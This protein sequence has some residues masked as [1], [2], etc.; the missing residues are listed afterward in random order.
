MN[1]EENMRHSKLVGIGAVAMMRDS[2]VSNQNQRASINMP[3][4]SVG[5]KVG[6]GIILL[7]KAGTGNSPKNDNEIKD[8][9]R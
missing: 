8:I 9:P 4:E 5:P 1:K 3:R 7:K 2:Y 6:A